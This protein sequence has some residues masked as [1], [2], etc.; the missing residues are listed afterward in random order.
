MSEE[1]KLEI[2]NPEKSFLNKEDVT[3]VVIPAFEEKLN[4]KGHISMISF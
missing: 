3:E 2:V 1:F 4:L